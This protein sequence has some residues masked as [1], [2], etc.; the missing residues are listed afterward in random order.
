MKRTSVLMLLALVACEKSATAPAPK[1]TEPE[2]TAATGSGSGSSAS[3]GGGSGEGVDRAAV[4]TM[5]DD[6]MAYTDQMLPLLVQWNGDCAAQAKRM[7][8]L[9]PLALKIRAEGAPLEQDPAKRDAYR[10]A[11]AAKKPEV[12][13][14]VE[15]KLSAAGL[16]SSDLDRIEAEMKTKCA[17]DPA[18]TEAMNHVGLRKKK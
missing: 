15:K 4:D 13:A 10:A 9:E 3:V 6:M 8:V 16:K 14:Q 11:M 7:M 1:P 2:H 18:Y 12:M 5:I 17:N